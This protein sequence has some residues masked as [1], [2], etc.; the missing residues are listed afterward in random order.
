[1]MKSKSK[2]SLADKI[3]DILT[4]APT[5]SDPEDD[6]DPETRAK[7]TYDNANDEDDKVE[8]EILS[9]FRKQNIDLLADIDE[10]YA[11]KKASRKKVQESDEDQE[12][13]MFIFY[14][15]QFI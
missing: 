7:L 13:G 2:Q 12:D 14:L 8:E 10:I 6:P 15:L 4:T 5:H 3:A 1:M 11:G 9:K